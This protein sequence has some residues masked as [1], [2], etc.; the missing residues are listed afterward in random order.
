MGGPRG[1]QDFQQVIAQEMKGVKKRQK[2]IKGRA[3]VSAH[4]DEGRFGEAGWNSEFSLE[5]E[6][7]T[8]GAKQAD[9]SVGRSANI[10]RS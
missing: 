9:T 1:S 7:G 3:Q 8:Y 6:R 5:T 10:I 4:W 2:E